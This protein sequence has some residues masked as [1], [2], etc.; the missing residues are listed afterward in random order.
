MV[1]YRTYA[2]GIYGTKHN[3]WYIETTPGKS[4]DKTFRVIDKDGT[5]YDETYKTVDEAIWKI[6]IETASAEEL[7]LAKKLST[8]EI[9][10]LSSLLVELSAKQEPLSPQEEMIYK[11]VNNIRNRKSANLPTNIS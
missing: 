6:D 9:Y 11:W 4:K 2:N 1:R 5:R 10:N 3:G 8:L 7:A